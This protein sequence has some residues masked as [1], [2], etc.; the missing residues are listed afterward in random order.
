M[1]Y[2]LITQEKIKNTP[3]GSLTLTENKKRASFIREPVI[4]ASLGKHCLVHLV[5]RPQFVQ[6]KDGRKTHN[7]C[8]PSWSDSASSFARDDLIVSCAK[9]QLTAIVFLFT[10]ETYCVRLGEDN[11]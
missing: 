11:F 2:V 8:W 7:A 1:K 4:E 6:Y 10:G 9:W 5:M 3:C